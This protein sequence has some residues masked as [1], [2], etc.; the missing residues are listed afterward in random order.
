MKMQISR[1]TVDILKNFSTIN[2]SI[3]VKPGSEIQTISTMKNILAK[4][5]VT[6]NF[7]NEFA[8]YDLPEFLNLVTSETFLGG[9]Y[10]FNEDYVSLEKERAQSTYYYADPTTIVAP[11]EKPI[12]M[13]DIEIEFDLEEPDLATIRNMSS[14]LANPDLVVKSE[15]GKDIVVSV[16]DKKDPT[17]NVFNLRV[18]DGNGDTFTMY[19]K[20]ENLKLLKGNYKVSI[21]SQAI[22]KFSHEDIDLTY[23]I[24]LEPDSIYNGE[25]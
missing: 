19:F 4:S 25:E 13:P 12:S 1:Q 14:I 20:N 15:A 24:A 8:I 21:S 17:S 22:S 6:E 9:E 10:T 11:P 7:V 3:L 16:L 2:P 18:G 5:A 23:W